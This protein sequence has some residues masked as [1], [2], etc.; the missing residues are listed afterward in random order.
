MS[1]CGILPDRRLGRRADALVA[2]LSEQRSVS[3]AALSR[4]A[5]EQA[6]YYRLL[7][8]ER[9]SVAALSEGLYEWT[10]TWGSTLPERGSEAH[11][12]LLQDTTEVSFQTHVRRLQRS[13]ELGW[14]S[15]NRQSGY[16]LHPA[17]AVEAGSGW[18]LGIADLHLWARPV[19]GADKEARR[20]RDQPIEQ[21][22]SMRWIRAFRH[23][24]ARLQAASPAEEEG[25]AL[26]L[27]TVGDR[28]ADIFSLLCRLPQH[29][30]VRTHALVRS[31]RDRRI[32]E[33][34]GTLYRAL[35]S[36]P[37]AG[38]Q[39]VW[40]PGDV[41]RG[42]SAGRWAEL[43]Y[44][45]TRV[46]LLRPERS[47]KPDRQS[48]QRDPA[49]LEVSAVEVR[50]LDPPAGQTPIRWRLLTTHRVR[51]LEEARQVVGWYR[52]RWYIE[53]L[54]RLL[55]ADG[56]DLEASELER[57]RALQRLA[58]LALHAAVDV[59]RLLLAERGTAG[60]AQP[61]AHVFSAAEEACLKSLAPEY[62]GR[63]PKQQNPHPKGSL[64]WAAWLI[65]R[66]GGWKG[67][68]SQHRAGPATYH[69]GLQRF[70]DL[71]IGWKLAQTNVLC[72]P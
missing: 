24:S 30:P 61:I 66:L 33:A 7:Q 8:N 12:L 39:R 1:Y 20:Y 11:V 68:R 62:E 41:R 37:P 18:L 40:L 50:E 51:T 67:Y 22:E 13:A 9:A 49:R 23:A 2:A 59:L 32:H 27:T 47:S 14:L 48:G 15:H 69:R 58:V 57:G 46:T 3:I 65:A 42:P 38:T 43:S 31:A 28:E 45:F 52:Q 55:K 44:R 25:G 19:E 64:A 4:D 36:A 72:T 63:T 21:K 35:E 26:T 53:Q 17:L 54:F 16:C 29:P 5:A 71:F 10:S 60:P 56:L 70:H 34:P 6:G